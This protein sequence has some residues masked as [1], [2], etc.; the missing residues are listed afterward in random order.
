MEKSVVS[1]MSATGVKHLG[2]VVVPI[3]LSLTKAIAGMA[4]DDRLAD[5]QARVPEEFRNVGEWRDP[6]NA[7][8]R[9]GVYPFQP[10]DPSEHRDH[11]M[12]IVDTD[13]GRKVAVYWSGKTIPL[14]DWYAS[15]SDLRSYVGKLESIADIKEM[16]ADLKKRKSTKAKYLKEAEAV[17]GW[18]L[19]V[20]TARKF[21]NDMIGLGYEFSNVEVD[22]EL[23]PKEVLL[24]DKGLSYGIEYK[25][26]NLELD[27]EQINEVAGTLYYKDIK[28]MSAETSPETARR[29]AE[30]CESQSELAL[31]KYLATGSVADYNYFLEK[32]MKSGIDF[33]V[34]EY[35]ANRDSCEIEEDSKEES[36]SNKELKSRFLEVGVSSRANTKKKAEKE[37]EVANRRAYLEFG[38]SNGSWRVAETLEELLAYTDSGGSVFD[39]LLHRTTNRVF[40]DQLSTEFVKIQEECR[41]VRPVFNDFRHQRLVKYLPVP[42]YQTRQQGVY[43]YRSKQSAYHFYEVFERQRVLG[44]EQ[45]V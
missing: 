42:N 41:V 27:I 11:R 8:G 13:E 36:K 32:R 37:W 26:P 19:I 22:E 18:S 21:R 33:L 10:D 20:D 29:Y 9:S 16:E 6:F 17:R 34:A 15:D 43:V 31:V 24:D 38:R 14:I 7:V 30:S 39:S 45:R 40:G 3:E 5:F 4:K 23:I 1:A 35:L 2:V 12:F 25:E 44:E 28:L